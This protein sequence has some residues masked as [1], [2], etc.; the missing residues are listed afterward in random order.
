MVPGTFDVGEAEVDEFDVVLLTEAIKLV[1]IVDKFA[2]VLSLEFF[3][4]WSIVSKSVLEASERYDEKIGNINLVLFIMMKSKMKWMGVISLLLIIPLYGA[5]QDEMFW[6]DRVHA[7]LSNWVPGTFDV[8]EA[9]VDEFDVVLLTEAIKLVDIVDKFAHVLSLEFF[10]VWSIVSKSVLEASE[11][12]DEKIGNINLVLFIMMKSKMKWMGVISLLLIIPLYGAEQDEMFWVDR[13]H[14]DL[15]N[16]VVGT[17]DSLD[18]KL[19]EWFGEEGATQK[20][21]QL[22]KVKAERI[23]NDRFFQTRRYLEDSP[24]AYIRF[25]IDTTFY[26]IEPDDYRLRVRAHIP[27]SRLRKRLRIFV[28][29]FNNRN[30]RNTFSDVRE[31]ESAPSVGV[32][33]FAPI[34]HDI[35]SKYSLGFSG[36]H[37]YVR[38]RYLYQTVWGHWAFEPAQTFTWSERD[39]WSEETEFYLDRSLGAS[40]ILRFY[41][42]RGTQADEPGMSYNIGSSV[43]WLVSKRS[44]WRVGVSASGSTDYRY[45]LEDSTREL[46]YTGIYSYSMTAAYRRSVWRPWLLLEVQPIVNWQK[47]YDFR[48]DYGVRFLFDIFVGKY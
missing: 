4:V 31:G 42:A 6:V 1:D 12:Y 48:T 18:S 2:H 20:E 27:F 44:G 19:M 30:Y 24:D 41:L 14:A 17:S 26:H 16:W 13:V 38:A 43:E 33:Y 34:F 10:E 23:R 5:E 22:E 47:R 11:R 28:E 3:E 7:D 39:G 36:I 9:E 46:R 37:P 35:V 21:N 15:S 45:T 8:G 25:R 32:N 40:Q 29:D